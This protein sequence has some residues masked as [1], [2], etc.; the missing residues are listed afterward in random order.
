MNKIKLLLLAFALLA[1]QSVCSCVCP[2]QSLTELVEEAYF[3]SE[4]IFVGD[5]IKSNLQ[6][7]LYAVE[8]IEVLKGDL[9]TKRID[10]KPEHGFCP[11]NLEPGRWIIY[12]TIEEGYLYISDCSPSRSFNEPHSITVRE[13]GFPDLRKDL[14]LERPEENIEW[15]LFFERKLLKLKKRAIKDLKKEIISLRKKRA[16]PGMG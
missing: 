1:Y 12:G 15:S 8:V 3:Y 7:Q 11:K 2:N 10:V 6:T 13:Y 9:K 14:N 16:V 5:V 4:V